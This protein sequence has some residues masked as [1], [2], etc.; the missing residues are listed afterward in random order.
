MAKEYIEREAFIEDI[1]TEIS[2]LHLNGWKGTPIPHDELYNFI[3]RIK[4]QPAADVVKVVR[5]KDCK[6]SNHCGEIVR[7]SHPYGL[8][9]CDGN[10]FCSYGERRDGDDR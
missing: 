7:C 5:C 9:I 8:T 4:E 6:S 1:K 10:D 3:D 2:N